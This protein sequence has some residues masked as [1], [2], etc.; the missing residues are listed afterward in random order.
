MMINEFVFEDNMEKW[1]FSRVRVSLKHYFV[2][3]FTGKI[4]NEVIPPP[5]FKHILKGRKRN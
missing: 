3:I 4:S 1:G 5:E 2:H